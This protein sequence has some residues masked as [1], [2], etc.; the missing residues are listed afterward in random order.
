MM[1]R[2]EH[3]NLVQGAKACHLTLHVLLIPLFIRAMRTPPTSDQ[4]TL[5]NNRSFQ[6]HRYIALSTS[7]S[8]PITIMTHTPFTS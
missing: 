5:M 1:K 8:L 7:K 3:F 2:S 4:P 6:C